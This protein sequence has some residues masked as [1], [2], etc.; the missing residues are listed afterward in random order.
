MPRQKKNSHAYMRPI[1]TPFPKS[2]VIDGKSLDPAELPDSQ[3]NPSF[4]Y[5]LQNYDDDGLAD[6]V[7]AFHE[8]GHA[9]DY[10]YQRDSLGYSSAYGY[11]ETHSTTM[12]S[13]T[14]DLEFLLAHGKTRDGK[15]LTKERAELFINRATISELLGLRGNVENAIFDI[16]LWDYDYKNGK[17]LFTDRALRLSREMEEKY[18]AIPWPKDLKGFEPGHSN[19]VTGHFRSGSVRYFGYV[20]AEVSA[21]QMTEALLD[22]LE[23]ETGR[24]SLYKQPMI[25]T[26]LG[27]GIYRNGFKVPFPESVVGFSGK[28]FSPESFTKSLNERVT[29]FLDQLEAEQQ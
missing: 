14:Q 9:L 12:E 18:S 19:F 11:A 17:E 1:Q 15:K 16:L 4:I 10:S 22:R 2:L 29:A 26:W 13:F 7:T 23:K 20:L 8:G 5:I 25:A 3:W 27:E 28:S 21:A 6:L 24:R